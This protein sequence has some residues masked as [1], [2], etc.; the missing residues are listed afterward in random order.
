MT[1]GHIHFPCVLLLCSRWS[2]CKLICLLPANCKTLAAAVPGILADKCWSPLNPILPQC[3]V[4]WLLGPA[5]WPSP[6]PKVLQLNYKFIHLTQNT[7]TFIPNFQITSP[8]CFFYKVGT[9]KAD[10]VSTFI[11]K[12]ST[13][14]YLAFRVSAKFLSIRIRVGI[15]G[16]SHS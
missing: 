14:C 15:G 10:E 2:I 11:S 16:M 1:L 3:N 5:K 12:S 13:L 9:Q 7:A 8:S 6:H 4:I